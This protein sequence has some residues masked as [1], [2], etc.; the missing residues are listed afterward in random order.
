MRQFYVTLIE[1]R[2]SNVSGGLRSPLG[3]CGLGGS[4]HVATDYGDG[5]PLPL[6]ILFGA[7]EQTVDFVDVFAEHKIIS[8][9]YVE[10]NQFRNKDSMNIST[11][12]RMFPSI[13][14][15][16]AMLPVYFFIF[17]ADDC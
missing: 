16:F 1:R 9:I 2:L 5:V 15:H 14:M 8:I 17:K 4:A 13:S 3:D 6:T 7:G 11:F 12:S 10:S